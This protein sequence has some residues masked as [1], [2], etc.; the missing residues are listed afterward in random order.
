VTKLSEFCRLGDRIHTLGSFFVNYKIT[1]FGATFY[2]LCNN[3]DKKWFGLHLGDFLT[4][5]SGHPD[6]RSR[7]KRT[8]NY[9]ERPDWANFRLSGNNFLLGSFLK[10]TEAV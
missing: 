4:N 8:E 1:N 7:G 6:W 9:P 3:F 2:H 5:A 10:N